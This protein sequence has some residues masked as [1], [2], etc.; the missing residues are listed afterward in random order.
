MASMPVAGLVGFAFV[1]SI[2]PGPNNMMLLASGANFGLRRTVPHMLG[3]SLGFGFLVLAVGLGFAGVVTAFPWLYDAL[4]WGGAA[5]LLYLAFKIATSA[6]IGG[7]SAAPRPM[8]FWQAVAFQWVNPKA[9]VMA[10]GAAST[11]AAR[12]HLYL[13]VAVIALVFMV[14]NGPCISSWAAFGVGM[15][16]LL[17]RPATMRAFNIAMAL[18]LVASLYPLLTERL[19]R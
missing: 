8:T 10:L 16:H 13:S 12:D 7:K 5:Y 18:L 19:A 6:G 15:R 17:N 11:Y 4:R 14:I 1:S 3:V 9:L 2:T